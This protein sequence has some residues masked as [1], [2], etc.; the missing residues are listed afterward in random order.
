[1]QHNYL[2]VSLLCRWYSLFDIANTILAFTLTRNFINYNI[3]SRTTK[4]ASRL[5]NTNVKDKLAEETFQF[6]MRVC[7]FIVCIRSFL[8][9]TRFET[10]IPCRSCMWPSLYMEPF[11]ALR[12]FHVFCFLSYF[13]FLI[14]FPSSLSLHIYEFFP[15]LNALS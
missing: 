10:N 14:P 7:T 11:F 15:E 13:Y 9:R 1:M 3:E 5:V 2:C 4:L 8:M 12:A 6:D